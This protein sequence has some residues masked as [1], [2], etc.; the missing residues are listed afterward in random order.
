MFWSWK[1]NDFVINYDHSLRSYSIFLISYHKE[2][3]SQ[4]QGEMTMWFSLSFPQVAYYQKNY[5]EKLGREGGIGAVRLESMLWG[6]RTRRK[7]IKD[8]IWSE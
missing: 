6:W 3:K 7:P 1:K 8:F 5:S 2:N 4:I